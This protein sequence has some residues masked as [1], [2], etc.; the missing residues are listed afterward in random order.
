MFVDLVVKNKAIGNA[1]NAVKS[2]RSLDRV[3]N[4][5]SLAV[6]I[7]RDTTVASS[8]TVAPTLSGNIGKMR[9][10]MNMELASLK[11]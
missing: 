11:Q 6:E 9:Q 7:V 5:P 10:P 1:V 8:I 3:N 4:T 2:F